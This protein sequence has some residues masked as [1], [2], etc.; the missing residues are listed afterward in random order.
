M[1]KK[2]SENPH[3][4]WII[5]GRWSWGKEGAG[6]S[7]L[8]AS[9]ILIIQKIRA[10]RLIGMC[11]RMVG[12]GLHFVLT[13]PLRSLKRNRWS[14]VICFRLIQENMIKPRLQL[15][16]SHLERGR[17]SKSVSRNLRI[18]SG[19]S[20]GRRNKNLRTNPVDSS[21]V[22]CWIVKAFRSDRVDSSNRACW[23]VKWNHLQWF[24]RRKDFICDFF[25]FFFR[26]RS[27]CRVG[28]P[29]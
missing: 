26:V 7:L 9:L 8:K 5:P 20:G 19:K 1:R 3:A 6:S 24:G 14:S 16:L 23:I 4:G 21:N 27:D 2:F 17:D 22:P 15:S 28:V 12:W 11:V 29:A 25:V 13:K 10:T 18:G